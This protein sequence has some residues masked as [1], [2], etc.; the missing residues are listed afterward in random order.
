MQTIILALARRAILFLAGA[1]FA[2]SAIAEPNS[3]AELDAVRDN[4]SKA[5]EYRDQAA[6]E[7]AEWKLRKQEIE[8][9]VLLAGAEKENLEAEL[10]NG[11][12]ILE[13]LQ[14]KEKEL[15][16]KSA[17]TQ[18]FLDVLLSSVPDFATMLIEQAKSWPPLLL[19][20]T[21][22]S[23]EAIDSLLQ[24]E[25][26]E[27]SEIVEDLLQ[28]SMTAL[29]AALVFQKTPHHSTTFRTLPDGR[30]ALFDVVYLGL[31]NGYY[32]SKDLNEAGIIIPFETEWVW[33]TMPELLEPLGNFIAVLN[34]ETPAAWV[35][36]PVAFQ[37]KEVAK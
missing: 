32:Y 3:V 11:R 5:L 17:Q 36:L 9:L 18:Q 10:A 35:N 16:E 24:S 22:V 15:G 25:S 30:E 34:E 4:L 1:L 21:H 23:L 7:R 8:N 20:E 19:T 33:Q 37:A 27:D 13:E 6:K 29:E 26:L 2:S 28:E 12:P 31:A 14:K